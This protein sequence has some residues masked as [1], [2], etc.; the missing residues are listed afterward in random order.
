MKRLSYLASA[1]ASLAVIAIAPA[2]VAQQEVTI[3]AATDGQYDYLSKFPEEISGIGFRMSKEDFLSFCAEKGLTYQTN[4]SQSMFLISPE[5]A[6]YTGIVLSFN[7]NA[8][9]FLTEIEIRFAD[10]ATAKA[11]YAEH[12]SPVNNEGD[13]HF[14]DPVEAY[15]TK[16]WQ[17]SN[18]I[19][20]VGVIANTRWS[21]Q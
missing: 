16:A 3:T 13:H 20:Y 6:D 5:G 17:F 15:R 10:E 1:L 7:S 9:P 11:Y 8:G 12:Y 4:S 19:F 2:A 18:K 14:Y 21:N